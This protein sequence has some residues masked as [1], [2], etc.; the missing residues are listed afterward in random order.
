MWESMGRG[1]RPQPGF[2]WARAMSPSSCSAVRWSPPPSRFRL[3]GRRLAC[4]LSTGTAGTHPRSKGWFR[5][6]RLACIYVS[7]PKRHLK[8]CHVAMDKD[9]GSPLA[10]QAE[11]EELIVSLL[12]GFY[13]FDE[14]LQTLLA[15][16]RLAI[17]DPPTIDGDGQ[18]RA[19]RAPPFRHCEASWSELAGD[20]RAWAR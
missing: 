9:A 17:R 20:P 12:Q 16:A 19:R 2:I 3:T 8:D 5:K 15:G 7:R 6:A 10:A 1:C 18:H 13:W 14:G 11:I 4:G